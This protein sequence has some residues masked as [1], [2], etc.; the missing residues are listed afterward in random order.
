M[1]TIDFS[2]LSPRCRGRI[3]NA[4]LFLFILLAAFA[5]RTYHYNTSVQQ[6]NTI[7]GEVPQNERERLSFFERFLPHRHNNFSPFTIESAMMF[8]YSQDIA[9]GKGVPARDETLKHM[10]DYAPY[11]QMNMALEWFL[12]W[13]WR[14]K[15]KIAPDPEASPREKLFQD[16]PYM[17]QWMSAQI[18]LWAS[19]TSPLIFLWLLLLGCPRKLSF[20]GGF[21]HA[22]ALSAIAR[23]T[24]QDLV[25]G[26][27][28]IP[29]ITMTFVLAAWCN[30]RARWWKAPIIFAVTFLAFVSWDL[31]QMI[32]TSWAMVEIVRALFGYRMKR[33]MLYAWA[34]IAAAVLLNALF[35]PFNKTYGLI[36]AP[37]IWVALPTLFHCYVMQSLGSGMDMKKSDFG[38]T[39]RQL[40]MPSGS[41]LPDILRQFNPRLI[42]P[43]LTVPFVAAVLYL[44]WSRFGNT[45]EYASNYSHFAEA[46]KAKIQFNNVKPANALLLNYDARI[47]WTP[48]MHS[49]TWEIASSFFPSLVFGRM[50]QFGLFR[51]LFGLLPVTLALYAALL[52]GLTL[53]RIPRTEFR[54]TLSRTF[55]PNVF[56]IGFIVG[57]IYIVRYHEFVILFL[58]VSLPMLVHCYLRAFRYAPRKVDPREAY[59]TLFACP[60]LLKVMRGCLI[61]VFSFVLVWETLLSVATPRRYTG[62]VAFKETAMMIMWFRQHK[63]AV[64]GKG[65]AANFTVGPMLKAYAGTGL[66]M[67]PQFGMK[68]I[69]DATEKYLEAMF[70]GT[71]ADLAKYCAEYGADYVIYNKGACFSYSIYSNRYI[72]GANE[73]KPDSIA[74]RMYFDS[75]NLQ[76]FYRLDVPRGLEGINRVYTVFKVITP[77]AKREAVRL[78]ALGR[79]EYVLGRKES[80]AALAKTA[81]EL[82]PTAA[83]PRLLYLETHGCLPRITLSGVEDDR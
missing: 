32:F 71:E 66:V 58:C 31:C 37:I 43:L 49:A 35:V 15:Q 82:D 78:G 81:V 17:A 69:R 74:N 63:D 56:T 44:F 16:H 45:P 53:F 8:S 9:E 42:L 23:S 27:F 65:V 41:I 40:N 77:E 62:D 26:E 33:G 34:A 73:I 29:L 24:G 61:A 25:R 18:R 2:R 6:L 39:M 36:H 7:I 50:L 21:L 75:D 13:G 67:N 76:W 1:K 30:A 12:G 10:E 83:G 11:E 72:A 14:L 28:C 57:F 64:A 38:S 51:F 68:R 4:W 80:A 54:R 59:T 79:S 20:C 60:V 46:M 3:L 5:F 48:S 47:M 55:L 22:V 52:L 70:H 19:L